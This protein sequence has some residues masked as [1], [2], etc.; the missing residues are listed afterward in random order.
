MFTR[1][2]TKFE[3]HVDEDVRLSAPVLRAAAE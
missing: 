2:F 3:A 1:N